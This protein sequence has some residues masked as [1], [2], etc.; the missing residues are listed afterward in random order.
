MS[1]IMLGIVTA[2]LWFA[3]SYAAHAERSAGRSA[4]AERAFADASSI[5]VPAWSSTGMS[6]ERY[7]PGASTGPTPTLLSAVERGTIQVK[8]NSRPRIR[9]KRFL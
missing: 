9:A 4:T 8:R 1:K 3:L 5:R 7:H 6:A 2:A